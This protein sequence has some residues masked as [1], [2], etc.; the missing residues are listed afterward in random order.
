M[1]TRQEIYQKSVVHLGSNEVF[2]N[3]VSMQ[4]LN[5]VELERFYR[6]LCVREVWP[7]GS[8]IMLN[9]VE[10]NEISKTLID[11]AERDPIFFDGLAA[12]ILSESLNYNIMPPPLVTWLAMVVTGRRKRPRLRGREKLANKIW[13]DKFLGTMI[14]MSCQGIPP[15]RSSASEAT[16]GC[17]AVVE[18]LSKEGVHVSYA[19]LEKAWQSYK[20]NWRSSENKL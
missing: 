18:A 9:P 20:T 12:R 16:S 1:S 4:K 17:D 10:A 15:T 2:K 6:S 8:E 5:H 13:M 14:V 11:K 19:Y 3:Y 7:D